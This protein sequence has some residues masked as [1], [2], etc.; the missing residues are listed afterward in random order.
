M[1]K[2][3][4][5]GC[6]AALIALAPMQL[7]WSAVDGP[8]DVSG[9]ETI[10]VSIKGYGTQRVTSAFEDQF[11]FNVGGMFEMMYASGTWSQNKTRFSAVLD[12]DALEFSFEDLFSEMA[13]LT[14]DVTDAVGSIKGTERRDGT[15]KGTFDISLVFRIS[16]ASIYGK[17]KAKG[18]FTGHRPNGTLALQFEA[19]SDGVSDGPGLIRSITEMLQ[20]GLPVSDQ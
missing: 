16:D 14:V 17:A 15:I 9:K 19:E 4:L 2:S 12:S 1:R 10:T 8:W 13:G 18:S 6:L 11:S 5:I 20:E 3:L 7:V